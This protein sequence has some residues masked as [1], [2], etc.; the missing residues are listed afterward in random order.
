MKKIAGLVLCMASL[1]SFNFALPCHAQYYVHARSD[2]NPNNPY[3]MT[4]EI[5]GVFDDYFDKHHRYP[6]TWAEYLYFCKAH[7]IYKYD[8]FLPTPHDGK[9]WAA[10]GAHY[11]YVIV[12]SSKD[13]YRVEARDMSGKTLYY[14]D[15]YHVAKRVSLQR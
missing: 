14:S 12:K 6:Q 3:L 9:I 13:D 2:F 4:V 10:P 15:K 8:L 7:P 11:R 1:M 5:A